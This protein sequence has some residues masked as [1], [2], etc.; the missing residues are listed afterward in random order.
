MT[1]ILF[2]VWVAKKDTKQSSNTLLRLVSFFATQT[3]LF[4]RNNLVWWNKRKGPHD[5]YNYYDPLEY[6][7]KHYSFSTLNFLL[8]ISR[9]VIKFFVPT[10][11]QYICYLYCCQEFELW[12]LNNASFQENTSVCTQDGQRNREAIWFGYFWCFWIHWA[13]CHW[14]CCQGSWTRLQKTIRRKYAKIEVGLVKAL[15]TYIDITN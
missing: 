6:V 4:N 8:W 5:T 10:H 11:K 3:L 2:N 1:N 12:N 15:Y 13:M 9:S 14:I 7:L